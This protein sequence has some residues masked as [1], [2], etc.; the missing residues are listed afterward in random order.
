MSKLN[1]ETI[2]VLAIIFSLLVLLYR[3]AK[4]I[5]EDTEDPNEK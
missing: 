2:A 5:K 3:L 1:L 4:R